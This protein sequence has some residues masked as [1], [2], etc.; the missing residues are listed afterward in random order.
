MLM[1]LR[2]KKNCIALYPLLIDESDKVSYDSDPWRFAPCESHLKLRNPVEKANLQH[3]QDKELPLL[4]WTLQ[5][6]QWEPIRGPYTVSSKLM[7]YISVG[8]KQVLSRS[9]L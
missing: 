4:I 2:Q 7:C 5:G 8:Y 6:D 1:I 9:C 3:H